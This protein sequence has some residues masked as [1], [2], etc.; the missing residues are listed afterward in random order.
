[1][2]RPKTKKPRA[3]STLRKSRRSVS[4]AG[5]TYLRLKR[6]CEAKDEPISAY[7]ERLIAADLD[8]KGVAT[9]T[10]AEARALLA[11]EKTR[12]T[13]GRSTPIDPR[14]GGEIFTF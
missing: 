6:Y 10:H 9:I 2:R 1:M 12:S 8:P 11:I 3:K 5:R 13:R 4:L 14:T 7:L